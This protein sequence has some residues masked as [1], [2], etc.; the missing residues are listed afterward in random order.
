MTSSSAPRMVW[1]DA[2]RVFAAIGV[3]LIHT[4][5]DFSGRAF[6]DASPEDRLL[7]V[8]GRALGEFS[9]S[10]MFFTFSLFLLAFKLDRSRPTW[11]AAVSDQARRLLIPFV[12][13]AVFYAFFRLVKA[14]GFGYEEAIFTQLGQLENWV[15]YLVLGNSQYHMHFLPTLFLL[16]LFFP[17]MRLGQRFPIFALMLIPCLGIMHEVQGMIWGLTLTEIDRDLLLRAVKVMGYVGY[18]F[19]AF[20]I[21]GLWKDGIPHGEARLLRKGAFFIAALAFLGTVPYFAATLSAGNWGTREGW[22]FWGHFLM[23]LAVFTIFVGSQYVE[24]SPNWS[25]IARY[26]FGVYLMHPM[27]IDLFDV[28]VH[29]MDLTLSP[30]ALVALRFAFVLPVTLGLAIL[31]SRISLLAWTI[32]LGP[33]PGTGRDSA[34]T[35]SLD[36]AKS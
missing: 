32:G 19:A 1:F 24:W 10:E 18:G 11:G 31:L 25:R 30:G 2:N 4:T 14:H 13:W 16:V 21:Y 34:R 5:T 27:V 29:S 3:I 6:P 12:F 22:A 20:A 23:P 36:A 26:S 28:A 7:P 9:G 8:I 33:L 35:T 15:G 17:V